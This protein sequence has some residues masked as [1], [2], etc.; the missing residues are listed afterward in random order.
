MSAI[1]KTTDSAAAIVR[2]A[3]PLLKIEDVSEDR[4]GTKEQHRDTDAAFRPPSSY[5]LIL[6]ALA[7]RHGCRLRQQNP[8]GRQARD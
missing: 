5:N 7:M 8:C 4:S 6:R 1:I 3:A 2:A